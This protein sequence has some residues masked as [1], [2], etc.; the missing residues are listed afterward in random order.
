MAHQFG[1]CVG[2]RRL[3]SLG[4]CD[5]VVIP[6][7]AAR[8]N[9]VHANGGRHAVVVGGRELINDGGHIG[10]RVLSRLCGFRNFGR[11]DVF[12]CYGHDLAPI[13]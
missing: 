11:D 1:K 10:G 7:H 3:Q 5:E 9:Q 12:D 4:F 13:G 8:A 6:R 2:F